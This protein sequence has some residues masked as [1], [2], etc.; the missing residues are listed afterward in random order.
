MPRFHRIRPSQTITLHSNTSSLLELRVPPGSSERTAPALTCS[1][2][3]RRTAPSG[4]TCR[5]WRTCCWTGRARTD[6][7][8]P[9]GTLPARST[10]GEAPGPEMDSLWEA[11]SR[12]RSAAPARALTRRGGSSEGAARAPRRRGAAWGAFTTTPS[13]AR[14]GP[15]GRAT[16]TCT[17]PAWCSS[18]PRSGLPARPAR[19]LAD[20]RWARCRPRA[21]RC[22]QRRPAEKRG[23]GQRRERFSCW[24][25][26]GGSSEPSELP[27]TSPRPRPQPA[28]SYSSCS[29]GVDPGSEALLGFRGAAPFCWLPRAALAALLLHRS[30]GLLL[31]VR[32]PKV[33]APKRVGKGSLILQHIFLLILDLEKWVSKWTFIQ[34]QR[35]DK[36]QC[37][38][39][40]VTWLGSADT[41]RAASCSRVST[42]KLYSK[43]LM[44]LKYSTVLQC[45]VAFKLCTCLKWE[46]TTSV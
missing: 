23:S 21:R 43:I 19:S 36:L 10:W 41:Y 14:A 22:R 2:L 28:L 30:R 38:Q 5:R 34:S 12:A 26:S 18:S 7:C 17:S 1:G 15:A 46:S 29:H 40:W 44:F 9:P 6:T 33:R 31:L 4:S 13:P 20:V 37:S 8:F 35:I 11:P 42:E 45:R 3:H 16:L 39:I 24:A 32:Q 25:R 27:V